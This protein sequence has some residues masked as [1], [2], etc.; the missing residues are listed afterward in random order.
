MNER[1]YGPICGVGLFLEVIH[2][3]SSS[4]GFNG[5]FVIFGFQEGDHGFPERTLASSFTRKLTLSLDHF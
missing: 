5:I 1:R 4:S 2:L 3:D